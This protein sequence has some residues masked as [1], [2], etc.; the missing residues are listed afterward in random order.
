MNIGR[1]LFRVW[2]DASIAWAARVG[3]LAM[4][5]ADLRDVLSYEDAVKRG[6]DGDKGPHFDIT[7]CQTWRVFSWPLVAFQHSWLASGSSARG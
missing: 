2:V 4:Q 7:E 3:Y 5:S 6:V 1:G